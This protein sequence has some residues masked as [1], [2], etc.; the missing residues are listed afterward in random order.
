VRDGDRVHLDRGLVREL[1]KTI[2]SEIH[3]HARNPDN[4]RPL[5]GGKRSSCR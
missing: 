5:G 3:L 1:I 2:P 4:N